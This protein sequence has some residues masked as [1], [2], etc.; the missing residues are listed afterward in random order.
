MVLLANL[1]DFIK[2]GWFP[3]M[4]PAFKLSPQIYWEFWKVSI[5]MLACLIYAKT[6]LGVSECLCV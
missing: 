6:I 1:E 2:I 3:G 4:D 5:L